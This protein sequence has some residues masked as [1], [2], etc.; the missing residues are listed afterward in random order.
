[1]DGLRHARRGGE[2][3]VQDD[4]A[5]D[6]VHV[7]AAGPAAAGEAELELG[8]VHTNVRRD[9]HTHLTQRGC[10]YEYSVPGPE[11]RAAVRGTLYSGLRIESPTYRRARWLPS[12]RSGR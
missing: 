2:V 4:L 12:C 10:D 6:L 7:L 8:L 9:F 1:L 3:P 5:A 11:Y